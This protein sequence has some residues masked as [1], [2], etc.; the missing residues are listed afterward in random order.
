MDITTV[1][2]V[3]A[4]VLFC[5]ATYGVNSGRWN[6]IGA[7]LAFGTLAVLWPALNV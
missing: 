3:F 5:L 7:G 6:L 1:F 2:L 4:F